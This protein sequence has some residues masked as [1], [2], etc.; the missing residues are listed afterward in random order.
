MLATSKIFLWMEF[1]AKKLSRNEHASYQQ[2]T[3][4]TRFKCILV[5]N[6]SLPMIPYPVPGVEG[7]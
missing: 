3:K 6:E 5:S 2:K 7:S 1:A 4:E